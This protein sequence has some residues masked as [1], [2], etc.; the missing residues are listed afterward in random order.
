MAQRYTTISDKER[1][2][3]AI[4]E[5]HQA[6]PALL[7]EKKLTRELIGR[8]DRLLASEQ[9]PHEGF[10]RL[11]LAAQRYQAAV[12]AI[13]RVAQQDTTLAEQEPRYMKRLTEQLIEVDSILTKLREA[14]IMF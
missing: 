12:T 8:L 10:N 7:K 13:K 11:H 4:Q 9:V 6:F 1:T 3:R 5:E 14:M 2:Q